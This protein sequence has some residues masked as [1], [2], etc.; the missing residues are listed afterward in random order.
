MTIVK[1]PV[2]TT[3]KNSASAGQLIDRVR[4]LVAIMASLVEKGKQSANVVEA[5]WAALGDLVDI[6]SFERVGPFHDAMD[7]AA[8]TAMLTQWVNHSEGWNP[9][10]KRM[11]EAPGLVF[12]Q[13]EEMITRGDTVSPFYSLS[14]YVFNDALKITR[15]EVYMQQE[16]PAGEPA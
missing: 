1:T 8:Y 10:V 15:I 3:E 16:Q 9:V 12:A 5:D 6:A 11:A 13:C 7:W 4:Q 14:M 2:E